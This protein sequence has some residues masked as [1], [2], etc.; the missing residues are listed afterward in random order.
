MRRID[1]IPEAIRERRQK[2]TSNLPLLVLAIVTLIGIALLG[3]FVKLYLSI[4][5][6]RSMVVT[7]IPIAQKEASPK[8]PERIDNILG[9]LPYAEAKQKDLKP[10]TPGGL[11]QLRKAAAKSFIAMQA[12]AKSQGVILEPISGFRSVK[13]QQYLFFRI[14]EQRGQPTSKRAEVS[15]PPGYSEHHTGYAVDIGDGKAPSTNLNQNFEKTAAFHWLEENANKYSFE[16]S[17]SRNNE[18]GVSYEPWHWRYVGD[19]DS[20][21]TFYKAEHLKKEVQP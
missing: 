15:A 21:E 4:Q 9:H 19:Q 8:T 18:Q 13:D 12:E 5:P 11:I 20:L 14:K 2:R 17:F 3:F 6:T 7:A 10:I 16:I 1:E